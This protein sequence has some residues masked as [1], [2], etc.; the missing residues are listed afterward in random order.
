MTSKMC[1]YYMIEH[2]CKMKQMCKLCIKRNKSV[3]KTLAPPSLVTLV[4]AMQ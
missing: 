3:K 2:D 4:I 1:C